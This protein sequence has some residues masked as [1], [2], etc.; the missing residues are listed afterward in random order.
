[1][2]LKKQ[3]NVSL[4]SPAKF[5]NKNSIVRTNCAIIIIYKYN[6]F[7]SL[8]FTKSPF[9]HFSW[10]EFLEQQIWLD[11]H[12]NRNLYFIPWMYTLIGQF[13]IEHKN[14]GQ[15]VTKTLL[16]IFFCPIR[17]TVETAWNKLNHYWQIDSINDFQEVSLFHPKI[18]EFIF[19]RTAL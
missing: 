18:N 13:D 19:D 1:M 4:H 11:K 14:I 6:L 16:D 12:N 3:K 5:F 8:R 10:R 15:K 9:K 2:I 7:S 17:Y